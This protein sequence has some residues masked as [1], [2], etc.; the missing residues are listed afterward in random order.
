MRLTQIFFALLFGVLAHRA[1]AQCPGQ[2]QVRLEIN[3]DSYYYEEH[4]TMTSLDG[5]VVYGSGVV[6]DSATHSFTYC[7]PADQCVR[8]T[9]FDNASDGF[10]PDG[11]YRIFVNDT[12]VYSRLDG[13][14]YGASES[15][16]F[17]CPPGTSC[18]SPLYLALGN[19]TT[20]TNEETWYTFTPADTG[21][22]VI[23]TCGA[24]CSTKIWVYDRCENIFISENQLGAI[25]FAESGCPDGSAAT[26]LNLAGGKEYYIR[27]RYDT[28][29][30]SSEPIPYTFNY[31]G[32]VVGCTDPLACNFEPLAQVS[33]GTCLYPGDPD[34]PNAPDFVVNED[35]LV[36][37]LVFSNMENPST[38]AVDEGCLRGL[39]TRYLIEFTTHIKNIGDED[40]YI[41]K[42]PEDI[43][44]PSAQFVYDPCHHHWHYMGYA[45]YLL[46]NS[47]G[48]RIPIGSKTGFCVLDLECADGGEQKYNC[49]NMG[50]SAHCGD[51]YDIGLPCQ[52]IDITD[53]PA[54]DYTMVV[55]VN[56]DQSPDKIGREE[57]TYDNNWAQAC[58]TLS[59]D[60][61]TPEVL[62]NSDSCQKFTDCTG[63][64]FGD[65]LPDCNGVCNG[66]ALIGDWNQDSLRN[67]ADVQAYL[68]AALAN[69]G[70][71]TPCSDLHEDGELN[72]FDAALLQE[73]NLHATDQQHW[74]QRFPC[75]F[76]TGFLN[77]QD[78]VTIQPGA[79]DTVAKTFTIDM[80]N[81]FFGVM[82]YEFSVS[83]LAI[84]SVE[85]LAT[86]HVV[87]P[88][89]NPTTGKILAL[90]GDESSI[91]KNFSPTAFL[92]LHY[93]GFTDNEV[94]VSAI[95]AVVN[96]KYQQSNASIGIPGCIQVTTVGANEP[97]S[98]PFAV[99]VQPNPMRE[100]TT[101]FFEN[102]NAEPMSFA[103][104]DLTGRT[105]RSFHDMRGESITIDRDGLPEG[106]Y[107]FTLRGSRGSVSGKLL[108][109]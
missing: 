96:N 99:F 18:I 6:P 97:V 59:Y 12:L 24:A 27:L 29:G 107:L 93:S 51:V 44:E 49:I 61:S 88:Q 11:Y 79:L 7:V 8:F 98:G 101:V 74:V 77:T 104:T 23:A 78:L 45:D 30:C 31:L 109:Q 72:V 43:N 14:F 89:F 36:S 50:I 42:P 39:G 53:I 20:P 60:G 63:V 83:G 62:F 82:G 75:Q 95:T 26:N 92:R 100:T 34:C 10:F 16:D 33:G 71:A 86:E 41:G 64:V 1:S 52:W 19:G 35:L 38:C 54:D 58:F 76:P 5:L 3:T 94:C 90:A 2:D 40:Y 15:V 103:L 85:N 80:A 105:L 56:W 81:P 37:S 46:Y 22:F 47:D 102:K 68:S 28:I 66:P 17:N 67:V 32:P 87:V 91:K 106:T 69:N 55:R 57:K 21:T 84:E 108:V 73:C 25:Y 70:T 48:Y 4:W 9:L 65:A 13:N